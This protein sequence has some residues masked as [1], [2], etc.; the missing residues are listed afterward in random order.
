MTVVHI[1]DDH[2]AFRASVRF[3]LDTHDIEVH[4]Y[5]SGTAFLL[6]FAEL[7]RTKPA[8]ILSDIRMP[9]MSGL[10]LQQELLKR[11]CEYPVIFITAHGDVKLAVQALQN[12][13]ANF[14]EKPF[15][16]DQLVQAVQL[17][18]EKYSARSRGENNS[19]PG[20]SLVQTLSP[21]ERQVLA[22]VLK[23][24]LNKV[25]ADEL[26]ISIKTVELHRGRMMEKMQ[27]RSLAQLFQT[28]MNHNGDLSC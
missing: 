8:C 23:G 21:R 27:A 7:D 1:I 24:K 12:G 16:E 28:V 15:S 11:E 10:E 26:G 22:L 18:L 13:A 25:I 3:L 14:L 5:P 20:V 9:A 6:A 2:D 17:A 4:D 19:P